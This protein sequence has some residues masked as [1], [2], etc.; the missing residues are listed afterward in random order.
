MNNTLKG[1]LTSRGNLN[2]NVNTIV[3]AHNYNDLSNK[4][5]INNVTLQGN[6]TASELGL[7]APSDI[8]VT[9]VNDQTGDV[10][11]TGSDIDYSDDM[12][13]NAKI[14]DLEAQISVS[15]VQSV[16]G[17]T[18]NVTLTSNDIDYSTGVTIKNKIDSV[19]GEIPDVYVS[20]VNGNSGAVTLTGSDII[21]SGVQSVNGAIDSVSE[22]VSQLSDDLSGLTGEDIPMSGTDSTPVA[23]AIGDL[24]QLSTT[25]QSSLVGAIN[26]IATYTPVYGNTSSGAIATFDT[27]LA[28]PLQDCTIEINGT[29]LT[30]ANIKVVGAN[31]CDGVLEYGNIDNSGQDS[32]TDTKYIRIKNYIAVDGGQTYCFYGDDS[33]TIDQIYVIEYDES[34]SIIAR[35]RIYSGG[36]PNPKVQIFTPSRSTKFIR[37]FVYSANALD[38]SSAKIGINYPSTNTTFKEYTASTTAIS[39]NDLGTVSE[40]SL[41]VTTGKLTVTTGSMASGVYQITPILINQLSGTNNVFTDTNGDT[42]VVYACS[43]KDYID[44]Q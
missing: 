39:W 40:G 14:N 9:S 32:G 2:G 42:S 27:S 21:Y 25:V 18:G 34:K 17:M 24:S 29:N 6:K 4:P 5:S 19:E 10:V 33:I 16:N 23:T 38:L 31:L 11:L 37:G 8:P 22:D 3:F 15:G 1:K 41:D 13:L 36:A 20:S 12:T 44:S 7:V 26:E 28:L 43:L 35:Y 30:G